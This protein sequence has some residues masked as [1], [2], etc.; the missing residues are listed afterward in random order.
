[1]E[2]EPVDIDELEIILGLKNKKEELKKIIDNSKK[3]LSFLDAINEI[4]ISENSIQ[5]CEKENDVEDNQNNEMINEFIQ[6]FGIPALGIVK[7]QEY[8]DK[9]FLENIKTNDL[10]FHES[11]ISY[12]P[13]YLTKLKREF[14]EE[15]EKK[16]E[17]NEIL[18]QNNELNKSNNKKN[19]EKSK[20]DGNQK[21]KGFKKNKE[22][23]RAHV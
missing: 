9:K 7:I 3:S 12:S 2:E 10:I 15:V 4:L 18:K 6:K 14:K 16:V 8:S 23:G 13:E 22:I 17:S 5:L 21:N 20:N 19:I 11:K 1:M